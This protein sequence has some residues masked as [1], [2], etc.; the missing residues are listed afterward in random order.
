[1]SVLIG[2]LIR[3]VVKQVAKNV[4]KAAAVT[5][6]TV[7]TGKVVIDT[8]KK[9]G[10]RQEIGE[11]EGQKLDG[12]GI[13]DKVKDI[14]EKVFDPKPPDPWRPEKCPVCGMPRHGC[15]CRVLGY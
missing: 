9:I 2:F 14:V 4:L 12:E 6:L 15:T 7:V 5:V 11:G 10:E 8:G 1:M 3:E 13:S